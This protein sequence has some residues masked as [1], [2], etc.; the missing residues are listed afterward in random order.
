MS[1]KARNNGTI[2]IRFTF[3]KKLL[4]QLIPNSACFENKIILTLSKS[5]SWN[6]HTLTLVKTTLVE[7]LGV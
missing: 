5:Q 3:R 2:R 4:L 1:G 6:N 7:I